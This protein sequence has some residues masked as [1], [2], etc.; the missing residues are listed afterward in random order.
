MEKEQLIK[1]YF[2][3]LTEASLHSGYKK[4]ELHEILKTKFNI[5]ST[6]DLSNEDF[7]KYIENVELFLYKS[8]DIVI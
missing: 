2:S 1:K 5:K 8:F 4:Q 7:E 6:K 3:K